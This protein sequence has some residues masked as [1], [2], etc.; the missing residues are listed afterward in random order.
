MPLNERKDYDAQ[1]ESQ[2]SK[3]NSLTQAKGLAESIRQA[4]LPF[5]KECICFEG[6]VKLGSAPA[7]KLPNG[8]LSIAPDLKCTTH[9]DN[10]FWIEVKDK[11]QRFY[12]DDTG[13]DL[14][15]VKGWY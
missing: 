13:A 2:A 12:F 7:V 5:V 15:Q 1:A 11:C 4:V 8:K 9:N 10:V 3:E 6:E 14:F